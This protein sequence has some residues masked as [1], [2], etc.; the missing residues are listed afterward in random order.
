MTR[1]NVLAETEQFKLPL[2]LLLFI[3]KYAF[4]LILQNKWNVQ[5]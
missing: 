1:D 4:M 2:M 3:L 5:V